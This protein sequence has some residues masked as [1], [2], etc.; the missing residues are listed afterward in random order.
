MLTATIIGGSGYTGGEVLRILTQH[1]HVQVTQITSRQY[2]GQ[3]VYQVHPNLRK[4]SDLKFTSPDQLE[5]T[6]ICFL[7]LPHGAAQGK[8]N[9]YAEKFTYIVDLSADFRL[10]DAA[11]YKK[12]Y[13]EDHKAPQWLDKFTYGLPE[14]FREEIKQAKYVSGVGCNATASNLAMYPL[15][16]ADLIDLNMPMI[17]EV[18]SG[19]SEGGAS[20]NPGS[21]HPERANVI[22]TYAAYGHRHTA[23]V[24]QILGA[25]NVSLTMTSVDVIRGALATGHAT[26]KDGVGKKEV[27]AA[28]RQFSKENPFVR[29]VKEHKGIYRVPEPKILA[30][31]NY[32]DVGF[33]IDEE[34]KHVIAICAIDNLMKGAAGSAVQ[35]M[36]LM[37]GLDETE[38]MT[39][40]GLHPA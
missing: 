8:I 21:H 32:A 33:D 37:L 22:R 38:G 12:W 28:Y 14:V 29:V 13:G 1:A 7:A 20:G 23:E 11:T 35:C 2:L 4:I 31:S 39:F 9:E 25:K 40:P 34:N 17:F 24:M 10:K 19:S 16:K 15:V 3:F 36:N 30:G 18:K 27:W 5:S 26:V 6:D